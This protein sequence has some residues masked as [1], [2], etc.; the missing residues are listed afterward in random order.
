[1]AERIAVS[2]CLTRETLLAQS[3]LTP[4]SIVDDPAALL[5]SE[6]PNLPDS[7]HQKRMI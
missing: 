3:L 1:M 4:D 7:R 2:S 6:R 5:E